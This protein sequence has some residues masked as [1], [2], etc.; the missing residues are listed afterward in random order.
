MNKALEDNQPVVVVTIGSE[1]MWQQWSVD[2]VHQGLKKV[3]CKVVWSLK[4]FDNPAKGDENFRVMPWIPQIEVLAHPAVK[5]GITH[6]GF[7]GTLEFIQNKVPVI[8]WPHF[9]DQHPNAEALVEA[10]A[11]VILLNKP[12][13]SGDWDVVSTYKDPEFD[14]E[15]VFK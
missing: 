14:S 3:G 9:F 2:T 1:M 5:A 4:G 8:A 7:G 15:H 13:V 11:G 12:R 6:C 10:G